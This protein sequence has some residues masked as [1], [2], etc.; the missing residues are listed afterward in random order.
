M[1]QM[2]QWSCKKKPKAF[3]W[4]TISPQ[5]FL[6]FNLFTNLC[7]S[8]GLNLP[9]GVSS[10]EERRAC[11]LSLHPTHSWF[12]SH[13][14]WDVKWVSKQSAIT[15]AFSFGWCV[16]PKGPWTVVG[17]FGPSL[18]IGD[19]AISHKLR[20][21][22]TVPFSSYRLCAFLRVI[23]LM[24][25]ATQ[26]TAAL[27]AGSRVTY[28]SFLNLLLCF[29]RPSRP[30]GRRVRLTTL[31]PSVSQ[32]SRRCGSLNLSQPYGPPRSVTGIPLL[33]I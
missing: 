11:T 32:L 33:I 25:S 24:V 30:G 7:M 15:L 20:Y 1:C 14:S 31:P 27:H 10:T 21:D 6:S 3:V 13:S 5:V 22:L 28:H 16:I 2:Y 23:R 19:F 26:L 8:Q 29:S 4:D 9:K 17:A 18:F 12:S